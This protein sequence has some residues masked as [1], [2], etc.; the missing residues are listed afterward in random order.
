V[1]RFD[2]EAKGADEELTLMASEESFHQDIERDS[3]TLVAQG[4][5]MA[6]DGR[7]R[8]LVVGAGAAG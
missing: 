5:A 1:R 2:N 8:V 7:K 6:H 4:R 3:A